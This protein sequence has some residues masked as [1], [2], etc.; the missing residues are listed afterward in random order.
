MDGLADNTIKFKQRHAR[1]GGHPMCFLCYETIW[2]DYRLAV[3]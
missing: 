3:S 1:E 2:F